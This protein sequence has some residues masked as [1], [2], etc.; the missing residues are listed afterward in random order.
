MALKIIQCNEKVPKA[1]YVHFAEKPYYQRCYIELDLATQTLSATADTD[2][3]GAIPDC[4]LSGLT[5]RYPIPLLTSKGANRAMKRIIPLIKEVIR[6]AIFDISKNNRVELY[7]TDQ[8]IATELAIKEALSSKHMQTDEVINVYDAVFI[9]SEKSD[10]DLGIHRETTDEKIK[11]ISEILKAEY[12]NYGEG[13]SIIEG[14]EGYMQWRRDESI[15]WPPWE[16]EEE[17]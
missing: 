13:P 14:V 6:C 15:L 10:I 8:I 5:R 1:L 2:K 4:V 16:E 11:Q 3:N 9:F 7:I 17:E 12:E